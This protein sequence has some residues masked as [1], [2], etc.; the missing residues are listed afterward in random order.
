MKTNEKVQ[1]AQIELV[2]E[3]DGYDDYNSESFLLDIPELVELI[4][5][6]ANRNCMPRKHDM[7]SSSEECYFIKLIQFCQNGRI[8]FYVNQDLDYNPNND[9]L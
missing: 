8:V 2:H 5:V 1:K 9:L 3:K 6:N 7:I 4:W